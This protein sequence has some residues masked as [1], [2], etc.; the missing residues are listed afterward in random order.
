M[1]MSDHQRKTLARLIEKFG[2]RDSMVGHYRN[3]IAA[4]QTG[5]SAQQ[6]YITGMMKRAQIE[7]A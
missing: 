7:E 1:K 2:E 5:Q 3:Q 6:M 4:S